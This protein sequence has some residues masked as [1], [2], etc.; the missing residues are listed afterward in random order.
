MTSKL[1]SLSN[2]TLQYVG[3]LNK[4]APKEKIALAVCGGVAVGGILAGGWKTSLVGVLVG[5]G[6]GTYLARKYKATV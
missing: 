5:V 1:S 4:C 3:S 2:D 6:V